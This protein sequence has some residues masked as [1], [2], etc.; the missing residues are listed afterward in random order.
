[1]GLL[2]SWTP[3]R[4]IRRSRGVTPSSPPQPDS[5][6]TMTGH[7]VD[8]HGVCVV[9]AICRDERGVYQ[10]SSSLVLPGALDKTPLDTIACRE[11]MALAEDL[12]LQRI[13]ISS[14]NSLVVNEIVE[15]GGGKQATIIQ[16]LHRR[17]PS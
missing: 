11:G 12:Q 2:P 16:G 15:K 4:L 8:E 5:L 10:G 9:S 14:S 17:L 13:V 1:M 7:M 3:G 6:K